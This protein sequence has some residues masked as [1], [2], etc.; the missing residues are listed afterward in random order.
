MQLSSRTNVKFDPQ[1]Q[2]RINET[3]KKMNGNGAIHRN[4]KEKHARK[5]KGPRKRR[6]LQSDWKG[7]V[8]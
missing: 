4:G 3:F 8:Q 7:M 1:V 6:L 5:E 2:A